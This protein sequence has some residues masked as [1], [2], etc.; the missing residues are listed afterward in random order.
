[1]PIVLTGDVHQELGTEEQKFADKSEAALACT[2]AQIAANHGLKVTLFFTGRAIVEND[3]DARAILA[4]NNVEIGG[5]GWD[6]LRPRWWHLMLRVLTGSPHGSD[7][8]QRRMIQRTCSV[9]ENHTGESVRSW[10][11]HAYRHNRQ[12]PY[13]LAA[14]N[15]KVWSDEVN[16]DRMMP[17]RHPSG[18]LALPINTLPDHE[19]MYHAERTREHVIAKNRGLSYSPEV[20]CNKVST[21]VETITSTGGIAT[22]LSHPICMQ[23]ADDFKTFEHLCRNLSKHPSIWARETLNYDT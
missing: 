21:Q 8:M 17:H 20:W 13:L 11:N 2:Y 23:I 1:M 3:N 14:T 6:A 4:M 5:H 19:N 9:I 18:T 7:W 10:R 22:I 12:T 15:I 16:L